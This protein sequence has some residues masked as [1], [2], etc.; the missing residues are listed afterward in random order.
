MP[1]AFPH[2]DLLDIERLSTADIVAILDRAEHYAV[3]NRSARKKT[4]ILDG[5]TVVNLFFEPS[6]RTRTSFEI[7]AKRL[8]A[9]VVNIPVEHSSVKKGET[10]L[11]TVLNIDAMQ[12]DALVVRH[13]ENGVPH[14]IAP[15]MKASVINAGDGTNEHPTQALLDA[16]TIR[17][18]KKSLQGL[19][20]T[21]SGDFIRS[22]VAGSF[23]RLMSKFGNTIRVVAPPEFLSEKFKA[24]NV[25]TF[26]DMRE[27]LREADVVMTQRIQRERMS[28]G[29]FAM[30]HKDY[31]DKFG[32]SHDKLKR[33]KPDAL[34]IYPGPVMRE[35]EITSL[36]ADDP[37]YSV[38]R[39]QVENGV[40]VRMA[41][42][43]LLLKR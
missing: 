27:A 24:L 42:L 31:H 20:I 28:E 25:E 9:D 30:S 35:A 21:Y 17:Q 32:L 18:K 41:V 14:F 15:Q 22:R 12:I 40:A 16:L 11:D 13:S 26:T 36:L 2:K 6:T 19:V 33:A 4:P 34:V 39:K 10:L 23:I 29:Q 37:A 38:I 43:D 5:R 1:Y 7:A 8:G 3:Q